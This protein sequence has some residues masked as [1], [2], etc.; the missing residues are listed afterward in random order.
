MQSCGGVSQLRLVGALWFLY[1]GLEPRRRGAGVLCGTGVGA[2][3]GAG[4]GQDFSLRSA[5]WCQW[6]KL[7]QLMAM[8]VHTGMGSEVERGLGWRG[9]G[10]SV[11]GLQNTPTCQHA[12]AAVP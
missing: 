4:V 2:E 3:T 11:E 9:D 1:H 5:L 12:A 6:E 7:L 10:G 8:L